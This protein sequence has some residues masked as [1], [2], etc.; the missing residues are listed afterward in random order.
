MR[1]TLISGTSHAESDAS[2]NT[3]T[4]TRFTKLNT[5]DAAKL[6]TTQVKASTI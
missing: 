6:S 1:I 3:K 2:Y 5:G 4:D